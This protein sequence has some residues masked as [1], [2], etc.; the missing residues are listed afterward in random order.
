MATRPKCGELSKDIV[1]QKAPERAR[2][3]ARLSQSESE[4]ARLSQSEPERAN[5]SGAL[6][7][8]SRY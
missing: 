7:N 6:E 5:C 1:S 2:E 4:R 8:V 3:R